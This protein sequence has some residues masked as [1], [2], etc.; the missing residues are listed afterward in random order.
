MASCFRKLS[1]SS[2]FLAAIRQ[3]GNT[4]A[5]FASF[6]QFW[7]LCTWVPIC[8][9][10]WPSTCCCWRC[11][12]EVVCH[13]V[14]SHHQCRKLYGPALGPLISIARLLAYDVWNGRGTMLTCRAELR[15]GV[16]AKGWGVHYIWFILKTLCNRWNDH[17]SCC[18]FLIS[19]DIGVILSTCTPVAIIEIFYSEMHVAC[20]LTT[21]GIVLAKVCILA[22]TVSN[23]AFVAFEDQDALCDLLVL[24]AGALATKLQ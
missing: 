19:Y 23:L 24:F 1:S 6:C 22:G 16:E 8:I 11:Y 21:I 12:L 20:T 7:T 13:W 5:H 2:I 9:Y 4:I 18:K 14:G 15:I 17:D 3:I 10:D